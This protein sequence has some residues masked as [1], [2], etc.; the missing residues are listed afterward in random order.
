M[1]GVFI[2][3]FGACWCAL[4]STVSGMRAWLWGSS[5]P[6]G[7][8]LYRSA[9]RKH[10]PTRCS[11]GGCL[12]NCDEDLIP[13]T[14]FLLLGEGNRLHPQSP[15]FHKQPST[16]GSHSHRNKHA[17]WSHYMLQRFLFLC[18]IHLRIFSL[19]SEREVREKRWLAASH[20]S[21]NPGIEPTTFWFWEDVLSNWATGQ[22]TKGFN[23][24]TW[25]PN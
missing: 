1:A 22:G 13:A 20:M 15:L 5:F 12:R 19:L 4:K 17:L 10:S 6:P 18:F 24:H 25:K 2:V 9:G 16:P 3:M 11:L 21:P 8:L 14:F 7:Q 23:D